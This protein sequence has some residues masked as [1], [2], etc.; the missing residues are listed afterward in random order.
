MASINFGCLFCIALI[1]LSSSGCYGRS[2][3]EEHQLHHQ[4]QA[5]HKQHVESGDKRLLHYPKVKLGSSLRQ[6]PGGP[7]PIHHGGP[8]GGNGGGGAEHQLHYQDQ[9]VHKRHPLSGD[10][11]LLHYPKVE[12]DFS[13]IQT[14][15]GPNPI[16]NRG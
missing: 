3:V 15:G 11:R 14:P 4:D 6:A 5:I 13:L 12:L 2:V 7:N 8:G 16:H 9:A 1:L 10:K